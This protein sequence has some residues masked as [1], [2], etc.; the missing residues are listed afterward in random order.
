[1]QKPD[2]EEIEIF[3]TEEEFSLPQNILV[4]EEE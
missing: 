1:L 2:E 3:N 4:K